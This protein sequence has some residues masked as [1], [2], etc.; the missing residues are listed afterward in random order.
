MTTEGLVMHG[1]GQRCHV[2]DW[3]V[4]NE[5]FDGVARRSNVLGGNMG[6]W[7]CL[8][9]HDYPNEGCRFVLRMVDAGN[10]AKESVV[11]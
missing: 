3:Y 4:P 10:F 7:V 6:M 5:L 9:V 8:L 2:S 1:R 11:I